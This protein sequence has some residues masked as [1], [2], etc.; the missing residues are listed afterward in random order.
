LG[1]EVDLIL[2]GGPCRIGIESTIVSLAG[3]DA[4]LL[5]PGGM[6]R[7]AIEALVG[8]LSARPA[9]AAPQAP[10]SLPRHY[11][12]HLPMRLNV[13]SV[14]EGEGLLAFGPMRLHGAGAVLNLSERGDLVEAAANLFAYLRA[15]DR[16]GLSA[17]AVMPIP[18]EGLG[19]AIN[20]RLRR[21]AMRKLD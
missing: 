19:E 15:L 10:G 17:I 1:S 11:A 7:A 20:D 2:D 18:D 9:G 14:R 16:P 8:P 6:P 3:P 12:P 13:S 4:L 5:R 21:A